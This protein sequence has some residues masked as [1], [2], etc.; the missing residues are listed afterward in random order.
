MSIGF[1]PNRRQR[2]V[3]LDQEVV[4]HPLVVL[5]GH[6]PEQP[7]LPGDHR[8]RE[9]RTLAQDLD[10][11]V[12]H[13][14]HVGWLLL[15]GGDERCE[16]VAVDQAQPRGVRRRR[17][18]VR[19]LEHH[20]Q[21]QALPGGE[22]EAREPG[23][24]DG[25]H[26]VDRGPGCPVAPRRHVGD[27]DHEVEVAACVGHAPGDRAGQPD[28]PYPLVTGEV[29]DDPRQQVE[30]AGLQRR[31][32]RPCVLRE[33]HAPRRRSRRPI[34][35]TP[36]TRRTSSVTVGDLAGRDR[37]VGR[38]PGVVLPVGRLPLLPR[39]VGLLDGLVVEG[40]RPTGRLA[41][42]RGGLG[43]RERLRPGQA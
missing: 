8:G 32:G 37:G 38:D 15:G 18:V 1:A 11:E 36:V 24:R 20:V 3:R 40:H 23:D 26:R 13:A 4:E 30:V 42:D 27:G 25:D 29:T 17:H 35:A 19:L 2:L 34:G 16:P 12:L 31:Q 22:G 6:L 33:P 21:A 5:H 43:Q 28:R 14:G 7:V 10:D 9:D 39:L 41:D